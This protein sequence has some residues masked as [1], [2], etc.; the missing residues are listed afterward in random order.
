[1]RNYNKPNLKG[2]R[3]R[4]KIKGLLNKETFD[5]FKEKYPAYNHVDNKVLK[6]IVREYNKAIYEGVI[7][8][9]DGV[10][11]PN[12]LGFLFIGTCPPA[13]GS[14]INFVE[15]QNYGKVLKNK[16]WETDGNVAKIFYTN[17]HSKY[18]FKN[19]KLWSFKA[20]RN[21]K[22]TVSKEYRKEWAKY[23]KMREK[24]KVSQ[25]YDPN[26]EKT[27]RDLKNYDEL[28]I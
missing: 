2:P 13:K 18:R 15:S 28:K 8:N 20:C 5:E 1:M 26:P 4:K 3:Y 11:L 12:S 14:N 27:K 17:W 25:V 21:F 9:R 6:N 24:V 10:E 23:I 22:R 19:R 7:D 16:N